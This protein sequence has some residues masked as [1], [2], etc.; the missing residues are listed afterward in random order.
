MLEMGTGLGGSLLA[1]A[2]IVC[3]SIALVAVSIACLRLR[4]QNEEAHDR[5]HT[6]HAEK[7]E[8]EQVS[9]S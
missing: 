7:H 4:R 8:A 6:L 1:S 2:I 9:H 3:L 5:E